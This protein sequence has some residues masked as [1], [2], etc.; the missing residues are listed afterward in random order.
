MRE[1]L[2]Q[3]IIKSFI[4]I[5]LY[6]CLIK[7]FLEKDFEHVFHRKMAAKFALEHLIC[8]INAQHSEK[9]HFTESSATCP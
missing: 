5:Y 9:G 6:N 3:Y 8:A 7:R 1:D 2:N 4:Y